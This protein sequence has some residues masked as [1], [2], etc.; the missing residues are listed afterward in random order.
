MRKIISRLLPLLATMLLV[1]NLCL[2]QSEVPPFENLT[3]NIGRGFGDSWNRY[4]WSMGEL[5]NQVYV[6]TWNVQ[7]DYKAIAEELKISFSN[8]QTIQGVITQL[9][10]AISA[11]LQGQATFWRGYD[12]LLRR[13]PRYGAMMAAKTG[14][15]FIRHP[16]KT[17]ASGICITMLM[18]ICMLVAQTA[19]LG[20]TYCAAKMA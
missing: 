16:R 1:S 5:N 15:R 8:Q 6:G 4:T 20:Q 10:G 14:H 11:F 9:Q 18:A 17:P 7:L 2:A 19:Q 12:S 3:Q 13:E